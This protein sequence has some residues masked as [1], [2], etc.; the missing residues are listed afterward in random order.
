M[1]TSENAKLLYEAGQDLTAFTTLTDDGDHLQFNSA[2]NFWSKKSGFAPSVKPNGLVTGCEI[3]PA[4]SGTN[5]LVDVAAGTAY[6]AGV[7]TT[8]AADTDVT[9]ARPAGSGDDCK[10]NS[11]TIIAAGTIAVV[12]GADHTDLSTVRGADG[13]PPWIPT[14]SIELGQI[15]YGSDTAGAVLS[16][17]IYQVVNTH[18]ERWDFP[19]WDEY[20]IRVSSQVADYA[21]VTFN[22]AL[23]LIHSDDAGSTTAGKLVYAQYY[24][25]SFA[26]VP[27][28]E[29]FVPPENTHSVSSTQIYGSTL[30]SSSSSLGQGSFTFYSTDG[31]TDPLLKLIDA[32]LMFKFY[33]DRLKAPYIVCQGKMGLTSSYPAGDN[34]SHSCTI[35]PELTSERIAS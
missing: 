22:A 16:T 33:P 17:E 27:K 10:V 8:I 11:I 13:G 34:M 3:T 32:T 1:P 7:L 4:A 19:V 28:A 2:V 30:G 26:E 5:N 14:T 12:A 20:P 9:C 15:K 29:N 35:S 18:L 23:P 6:I 25:P 21:G 31:V 24:E